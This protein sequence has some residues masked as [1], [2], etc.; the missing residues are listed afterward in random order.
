MKTLLTTLFLSIFS[1]SA[2]STHIMGG[3]IIAENNG[4]NDYNVL[5]TIYRDT[6]GIPTDVNQNFSVF[7]DMGNNIMN[8]SMTMDPS[9]NHPIFGFQN[10]SLLPFFP[11]GVEIYFF[12]KTI[13]L[14]G[15][16]EYTITWDKCC[17]NGAIQNLIDPLSNDMRLYTTVTVDP[18]QTNSTPYFMVKPVM[19]LPVN[20]PWQYNPLPYDVNGDSLSWSLGAPHQSSSS[21]SG[22]AIPGYTAP[23]SDPSGM[24]S[25]DPVTGTISWTASLLGNWVYTVICEEYRNGVKIGE[26][27][28][29][30]QFI[31]LPS[32]NL[33]RF[34]NFDKIPTENGYYFWDIEPGQYSELRLMASDLDVNDNI[35]FEAFG[36]PFILNNPL[37]F[38]QQATGV[39]NQIETKLS[40]TPTTAEIKEDPYLVVLRLMDGSYMMDE[41]LFIRVKKS[42]TTMGL[43]DEQVQ[44]G[45]I[46]PNPSRDVVNIP[47]NINES[48]N[49]NIKFFNIYGQLVLEKSDYFNIGNH[50]VLLPNDL[51]A[52]QYTVTVDQ[53]SKHLGNQPIV[54]IK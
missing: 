37:S 32:G 11:Y 3:E 14:P 53:E 30:M 48:G 16:G 20:T 10:G 25:I 8:F 51:P 2:L 34:M 35:T 4:G 31:V 12:S 33:P 26:I 24:I 1:F 45:K 17:R 36:E 52:G 42:I 47:L 13:T 43:L 50:M 21:P 27:R 23:P 18:S 6:V 41:A 44:L 40:W 22:S 15:T 9:A 29:D 49:V 19:Y 38:S 39:G 54:I 5:L 28:R 7:D 46:F